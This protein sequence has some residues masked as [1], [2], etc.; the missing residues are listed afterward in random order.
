VLA[1]RLQDDGKYQQYE[2]SVALEGLP[3]SLLEQTLSKLKQ[4]MND[5]AAIWFA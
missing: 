2:Y 1:F 5:S 4:G 3:I